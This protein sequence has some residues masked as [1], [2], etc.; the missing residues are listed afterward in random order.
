MD[1]NNVLL[2]PIQRILG[3]E[4]RSTTQIYL[5]S[6]GQS[7]RDAISVYEQARKNSCT[8]T[9]PHLIN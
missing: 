2:G 5:H 1:E 8:D 9:G 4:H 7:E 3:H 6:L